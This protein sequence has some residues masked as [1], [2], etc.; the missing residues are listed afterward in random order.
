ME[1]LSCPSCG[2]FLGQK[3]IEYDTKKEKICELKDLSEKEKALKIKELLNSLKIRRYCC[4]MRLMTS[5]DQSKEI[6]PV[7]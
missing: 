4:K 2:Y 6:L 7:D 3:S 1:Y 5:K